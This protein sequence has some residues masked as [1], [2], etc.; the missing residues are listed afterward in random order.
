MFVPSH[1]QERIFHFIEHEFGNGY[2]R[3]AAGSGKTTT[4]VEGLNHVPPHLET[5][6]LAFNRSVADTLTGRVPQHTRAMTVHQLGLATLSKVLPA[7]EVNPYKYYRIAEPI[8]RANWRDTYKVTKYYARNL[9]LD[10][11]H[12]AQ[13]TLTNPADD[14]AMRELANY[15]GL[16]I[17]FKTEMHRWTEELLSTGFEQA[18]RTGSV[19]FND[20]V[21]LPNVMPIV[22][23][24]YDLVLVDEA[25][26]LSRAQRCLTLKALKPGGR[27]IYCTD[28]N[29]AIYGF[30]GADAESLRALQELPMMEELPLSICYRCPTS[31]LALAQA[32]VPD[33]EAAPGAP[34]GEVHT[35][36]V[37]DV[38]TT[39]VPGDLV[40][41]RTNAPLYRLCLEMLDAGI[42]AVIQGKD[43]LKEFGGLTA[44]VEGYEKK[45]KG[46]S[47]ADGCRAFAQARIA[48][49]QEFDNVD[50]QIEMV[51][52]QAEVIISI[53]TK[54]GLKNIKQVIE[55]LKELTA[56]HPNPVRLS[57]VHRAKGSEADRVII[58]HPEL[59]PHPKATREWEVSQELNLLYVALTRSK[60]VLYFAECEVK[61]V[62]KVG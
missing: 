3:A 48:E 15:Y 11:A 35:I 14:E 44:F 40:L 53:A 4:I 54:R 56:D 43:I 42:P 23:A 27:I 62:I 33:I 32:L 57:S 1:Y 34:A 6:F 46:A 39:A 8:I 38:I 47:L 21:W 49:L 9:L 37:A 58:L 25:Q 12:F 7:V 13:V 2:I 41:C 17:Q 50:L 59:M 22:P 19:S 51:R 5:L 36:T 52:D 20:M 31:H 16:S 29:Q 10:Y 28:P 26:D 60:R 45:N 30:N 24:Q 61:H 55:V 18:V